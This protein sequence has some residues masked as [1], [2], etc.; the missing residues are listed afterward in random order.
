MNT[1][2]CLWSQMHFHTYNVL[3]KPPSVRKKAMMKEIAF[4]LSWIV[5][6]CSISVIFEIL[7]MAR[8]SPRDEVSHRVCFCHFISPYVKKC[9]Q[10]HCSCLIK[11]NPGHYFHFFERFLQKN[12]NAS[13]NTWLGNSFY[14]S[15]LL[16]AFFYFVIYLYFGIHRIFAE[17]I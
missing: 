14:Y 6:Y 13:F 2:G 10:D 11:N 17:Q 5:F 1:R 3:I 16:V 9:S 15:F 4:S 12:T 7:L 8:S